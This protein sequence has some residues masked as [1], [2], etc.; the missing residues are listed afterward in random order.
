[1]TVGVP[2]SSGPPTSR[3]NPSTRS[4]WKTG[5]VIQKASARNAGKPPRCS[6]GSTRPQAS[7]GAFP[8]IAARISGNELSG[9]HV[10]GTGS[11]LTTA[12]L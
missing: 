4:T 11:Q 6:S 7:P 1:M 10:G 2:V 3:V 9:T 8:A 5:L 12:A